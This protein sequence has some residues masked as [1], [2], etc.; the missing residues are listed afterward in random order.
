MVDPFGGSGTTYAAAE[1]KKRRWVGC[2]L[3]DCAPIIER[4]KNSEKDKT[5]LAIIHTKTGVLLTD[6]AIRRRQKSGL[7][8]DSFRISKE[9]VVRALGDD[10]PEDL[11]EYDLF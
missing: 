1:L 5:D 3:G 7:P 10:C 8:I 6:D 11:D 9:Q 2:E 4:L